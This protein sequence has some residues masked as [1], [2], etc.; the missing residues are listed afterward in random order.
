MGAHYFNQNDYLTLYMAPDTTEVT[1]GGQMGVTYTVINRWP[2]Y[3]TFSA[4]T[5]VTLPDGEILTVLGPEEY[6]IC[7]GYTAQIHLPYSIPP[8]SYIGM[9]KYE[10]FI[11]LPSSTLYDRDSFKFTVT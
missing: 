11:G 1:P 2:Q 3:K 4:L 5:Q 7:P 8:C 9:Y 6:T 10:A